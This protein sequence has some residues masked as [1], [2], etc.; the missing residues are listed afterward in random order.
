MY[1]DGA[2]SQER[3]KSC[4]AYNRMMTILEL[5]FKLQ[6]RPL[7]QHH[8]PTAFE[9]TKNWNLL[10]KFHNEPLKQSQ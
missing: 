7:L 9:N 4:L 6:G 1:V 5:T 3:K 2:S 10:L 8:S